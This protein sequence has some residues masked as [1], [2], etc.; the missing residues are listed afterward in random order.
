MKEEL[1]RRLRE[2]GPDSTTQ[3]LVQHCVEGGLSVAQAWAAIGRAKLELSSRVDK[4][5]RPMEMSTMLMRLEHCYAGAVKGEDWGS[6]I[7]AIVA[8]NTMLG[9][10]P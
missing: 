4:L 7:K 10:K 1:L 6:A 2:G 3:A 9:L 8:A 5:D